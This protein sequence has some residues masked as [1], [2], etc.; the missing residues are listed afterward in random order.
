MEQY[1]N[2]CRDNP[3][4]YATA[5]ERLLAAI[6]EAKLVN[7]AA[8]PRLGRIFENRTIK[9]FDSFS[10]FFGTEDAI[11]R[12]A[13]SIRSASQG[14]EMKKQVLYLLGPVGGGKSS[15]AERLKDLM[16]RRP[17]YVLCVAQKG[18]PDKYTMS[19]INESPL[20]LIPRDERA[21]VKE[22]YGIPERLISGN[23]SPW[24]AKRLLE[25][26]GD[27]LQFHVA[28]MY[29][30][31]RNQ[32]GIGQV[33]P[34]DENNQDIS[35]LVGKVDVRK[36]EDFSPSDPDA[37]SYT[38]ALCRG[39]QG[40]VEFVEMFKA[41][42]KMLHPLLTAT[43]EGVYQGTEN[44]GLMPFD[45]IIFAHSNEAEWDTFRA[46]K[47]NEA[48]LDRVRIV[49]VKY[50]LR[51]SDEVRIFKKYVNG[52]ALSAMPIAPF[53]LELLAKVAVMSR[54]VS[55]QNKC[56]WM[57]K[58]AIYDGTEIRNEMA[59]APTHFALRE[60]A[61]DAEGMNGM[62]T[63]AAFKIIERTANRGDEIGMD[64]VELLAV[65]KSELHAM[66]GESAKGW[67]AFVDEVSKSW[68]RKCIE[69]HIYESLLEN[70]ETY[71]QTRW[72]RYVAMAEVATDS[73][74]GA[75]EDPETGQ[76]LVK[77][78]VEEILAGIEKPSGI[79]NPAQFRSELVQWV[80]RSKNRNGNKMPAWDEYQPMRKVLQALVRRDAEELLPLMSF[81][82][83]KDRELERKHDE[84][85]ERMQKRGYTKKQV[86]RIVHWYNNMKA[87]S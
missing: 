3:A 61:G 13:D 15:M 34:G 80:L 24:A 47:K 82:P 48:F 69:D 18:A 71:L 78:K 30:S 85:V 49:T 40:I 60:A 53:T 7:T 36:L 51:E 35:T 70:Y 37:Y 31:I 1:L 28:E 4:Y 42:Q 66:Y 2:G 52:S 14:L 22:A 76:M 59:N 29:P 17:I 63:R 73:S 64:P 9:L 62:S 54:M 43:Q 45:G 5:A 68:L 72:E 50:N 84:F 46:N 32:I 58:V 21:A 16:Q 8:D 38:G 79:A 27:I 74:V 12:I 75:Y 20:S 83:K 86:Q 56:S 11:E 6:G 41:P 23:C 10:D 67:L 87:A 25:F 19:P 57:Q 77:A 65:L 39:N 44:I 26:G 81:G 55:T 33:H